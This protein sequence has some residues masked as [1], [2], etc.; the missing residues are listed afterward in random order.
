MPCLRADTESVTACAGTA[1]LTTA[2]F[3]SPVPTVMP[4]AFPD[5][6]IT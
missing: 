2:T 6:S 1:V 4:A 5:C 3:L